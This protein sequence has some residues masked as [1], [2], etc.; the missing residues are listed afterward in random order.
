MESR[1]LPFSK[2][3][4]AL[5]S[6]DGVLAGWEMDHEVKKFKIV[7]ATPV[8]EG[9]V[10]SITMAQ[11]HDSESSKIITEGDEGTIKHAKRMPGTLLSCGYDEVLRTHDFAKRLNS[12]GEVRTPAEFGTP[13]CSAFAPPMLVELPKTGDVQPKGSTHCIVGFSEGK[14]A[15]YKKKDW[16]VQHLL[17]GHDGGVACIAVHPS[18]KMALTGGESDGKLKLWDLTKGR[19]AFVAKIR[20]SHAKEGKTHYDAVAHIVWTGGE[21]GEHAYAFC[22]GNHI[23]VRDV[24]SGEDLLDVDLPSRVNQVCFLSLEQGLF[25]AAAC[26]DGS[27]PVLA[28][29]NDKKNERRAIMAIE[30]V[31]GSVAGEERFKCIQSIGFGF[32][33]TANSAGVV[34]LMDLRGAV[35]MMMSDDEGEAKAEGGDD[36]DDSEED[37]ELAVEIIDGV[38]LGTGA[39]VTCLTAW[40]CPIESLGDGDGEIIASN[41][42]DENAA[43]AQIPDTDTTTGQQQ[44]AREQEN[45]KKRPRKDDTLALDNDSLKRARALV[46]SAR[47]IQS[48]KNRKNQKKGIRH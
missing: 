43:S 30:P 11:P 9:S 6:Y 1:Q 36:D 14:L 13:V 19:L 34:S 28:V 31:D 18:G 26:N 17:A 40:C 25:V 48:K 38:Q 33:V 27:L 46:A 23:T 37:E 16:S 45:A 4:V 22:Y 7:F 5:G 29:E 3:I 21:D 42:E 32:V 44:S 2:L 20:P 39:R 8:H 47:Q 41:E 35:R 24:S 10:R 12:A 15:I